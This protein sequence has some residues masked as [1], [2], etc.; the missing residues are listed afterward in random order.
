MKKTKGREMM[1]QIKEEKV[2]KDYMNIVYTKELEVKLT[3]AFN[4]AC[5]KLKID[6]RA[7][8]YYGTFPE[9]RIYEDFEVAFLFSVNSRYRD[10]SIEYTFYPSL[11]KDTEN[12]IIYQEEIK[13]IYYI[14]DR[15]NRALKG[16]D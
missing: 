13:D 16:E 4:E 6:E 8:Y 11:K 7:I 3:T 2:I 1:N 12:L 14:L 15:L 10:D 9:F 5:E